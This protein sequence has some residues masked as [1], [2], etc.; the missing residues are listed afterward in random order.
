[1]LRWA[2]RLIKVTVSTTIVLLVLCVA[3]GLGIYFHFAKDLPNI[4]TL[5]DYKPPIV[6]EVFAADGTKIGEFWKERRLIAN[7][8]E[9]PRP[10]VRAFIAAEDARFF[11]H[12]GVDVIG[13]LRALWVD[14]KAG[15]IVEGASTITQQI[16]RS[17]VLTR[18]Q[19]VA[20]KIKEAILATRLER[21]LNKEQIL[22]LY[23]NQIFLGNRAYGVK[24]AAENYFHKSLDQLTLAEAAMIGGLSRLPT[25]DSP[26]NSPERAKHRQRYVLNR[27]RNI[28]FISRAEHDAAL[29]EPLRLYVAETDKEYNLRQTPYFTEHIRRM[30]IEEYGE[31]VVYEGGLRIETMIDPAGYRLAE[32]A[33]REGLEALDRRQGYRGPVESGMTGEAAD[34]LCQ[35]VHSL[36]LAEQGDRFF[37][38]PEAASDHERD[39]GPTPLRLEG[40]Y[41]AVVTGVTNAELNV[42]VGNNQGVVPRA[43]SAWTHRPFRPGDVIEVRPLDTGLATYAVT[44]TPKVQGAL[45]AMEPK[46]GF[47]RAM[48]GG[49]DYR[50]SEFNRATQAL[51]QPGSSFKPFVYASALDKGFTYNT[52]VADT[53]VAYKVGIHEVWAPKNYGG[54]FSGVGAFASHIT[55]SR[56]VPTVKIGRVVGLHYLTAFIRKM[57]LTSPVGKYLSMSLGANG[58]YVN[59]MVNAYSTFANGGKKPPQVYITKITDKHGAIVSQAPPVEEPSQVIKLVDEEHATPPDLNQALWHDNEPWIEKDGLKLDPQEIQVL[60]G[61]KIPDGHVLTPQ[62]AFLTLKL[63]ERV[64]QQGTGQRVKALGRPVAGKTGTTN[65][66]TDVWFIGFT[67]DLAAGVW[68]GYDELKKLGRGEQGGRTAA[69]IFL[70]YMEAALVNVPPSDFVPPP[71]FPLDKIATLTGGCAS[72]WSGGQR[73]MAEEAQE[74]TTRRIED[75][76]VDFF[77]A[78]FGSF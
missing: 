39:T 44:Q 5:E 1:M 17:I 67:P 51:R 69:P 42:R 68:I 53:P 13:I 71:E 22:T 77:E 8:S 18:E 58:V 37:H 72:Y 49:Y 52:P 65:D 2:L 57:G 6:S 73:D 50:Q 64:V 48:I 40:N 19:S 36:A 75:R 41:R 45:F 20:R 76:A 70:K 10:L 38:I 56:N 27:M 63:L 35:E 26:I 74:I 66:E 34:T 4:K 29:Q 31:D 12:R 3:G 54:K 33:L 47:V 61:G 24:A 9:I 32:H 43:E 60:Y 21:N 55:F 59:E 78:D 7:L 16:T 62:T 28:G 15:D 30:L 46:T 11:E 25:V 23:L 14:L